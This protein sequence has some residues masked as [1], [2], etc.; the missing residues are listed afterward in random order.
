MG[1]NYVCS[2]LAELYS[3]DLRND[4]T[5][6]LHIDIVTDMDIKQLH[7]VCVVQGCSLDNGTAELHRLEVGNRSYGSCSAHLVVNGKK[8]GEGLLGLEFICHCPAWE[9]GCVTELFLVWKF[10]YL[11]YDTVSS[12]WE[13]LSLCVP[14]FDEFLDILDA[15]AYHSLI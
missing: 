11:D 6:F 4:L 12:E 7:L 15:R 9:L 8:F 10:V 5:A 14:V 3:C 13:I 1:E 2:A